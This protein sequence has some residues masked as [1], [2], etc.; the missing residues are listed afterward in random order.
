[1]S[2]S[3]RPQLLFSTQGDYLTARKHWNYGGLQQDVLANL[4]RFT[5]AR[6]DECLSLSP[7]VT[8]P[9][10]HDKRHVMGC[11]RWYRTVDF[12]GSEL[13]EQLSGYWDFLESLQCGN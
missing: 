5:S 10:V 6:H 3:G 9:E 13:G 12:T 11:L 4:G 1:M 7:S 2:A 8:L